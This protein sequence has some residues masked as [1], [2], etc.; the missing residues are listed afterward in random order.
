M[1]K[2]VMTC[3]DLWQSV[4]LVT[5][6][7][8]GQ[9]WPVLHF[10]V[11]NVVNLDI[12]GHICSQL[13][14]SFNTWRPSMPS[15]G[16]PKQ[17]ETEIGRN[18]NKC[19]RKA[20]FL[21]ETEALAETFFSAEHRFGWTTV[22]ANQFILCPSLFWTQTDWEQYQHSRNMMERGREIENQWFTKH[23]LLAKTVISAE[24]PSFGRIAEREESWKAKTE[25][26]FGRKFL[27]K[28]NRNS[29]R[30]TTSAIYVLVTLKGCN[31][32]SPPWTSPSQ[33]DTK[34]KP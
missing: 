8:F 27:P 19:L 5:S 22:S 25:I 2:R 29:I 3:M 11:S 12:I 10:L 6:C 20:E 18:R 15:S 1:N 32:P 4:I 17:A 34:P 13:V 28:P 33:T 21:A 16:Q 26:Y 31:K 24:T 23:P 9:C 7:R 30:L 14:L